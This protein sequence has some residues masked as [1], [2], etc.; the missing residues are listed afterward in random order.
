MLDACDRLGML[1]MDETFDVWTVSKTAHDHSLRFADWWERDVDAL[2]AQV[3]NHPSVILYSIGNEIPETGTGIGSGWGRRLAERIR[4]QDPT[5][6][7]TNGINP[8]VSVLRELGS[9]L[10]GGAEVGVNELMSSMGE[11][12]N[13]ISESDLVSGR[14]AESFAVLDVAGINYGDARYRL[15]AER[16]PHRVI[17]GSETFPTH[18]AENWALVTELDHVIGDFTWTG[19]DY[20]GETGIGRISHDPASPVMAAPYPWLTAWCGDIDITGFRRPVS[21]YR[22]LVFGLTD[23]PT[24]AVLRPEHHGQPASATPWSWS[25]SIASWSFDVAAG[26]PVT[27]EV[28]SAAP[29]VE[30]LVGGRSAGT[31]PAGPANRFLAVFETTWEPGEVV[32]IDRDRGTELRRRTLRTA[33]EDVVLAATAD[34]TALRADD[35]DLAHIAIELVDGAGVLATHRGAEVVVTVS[36]AG[37]LEGIGSADPATAERFDGDRVRTFDGRAIAVVR[38]SGPGAIEVVVTADGYAPV[39]IG[40]T[41]ER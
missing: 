28:Y 8:M 18:I 38:P 40:L 30:L 17:V 25:D 15:D 9:Q 7:I 11:T 36:G 34:R 20:L 22:E 39:T 2:V 37:V 3:V 5:R 41:A 29:E 4:A 21:Y 1:V 23:E 19:W 14:T 10:T 35:G 31:R 16:F 6:Y 24:I 12:M 27:V 26:S 13:R 32:A 33:G